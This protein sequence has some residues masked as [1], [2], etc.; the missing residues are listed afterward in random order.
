MCRRSCVGVRGC[1]LVEVLVAL[2]LITI[3]LTGLAQLLAVTM[4]QMQAARHRSAA[5][6]LAAAKLEQLQ[7]LT[8]NVRFV[9]GVPVMGQDE[10]T[11]LRIEP[12]GSSG[13]GTREVVEVVDYL[14]AR[15]E[16]V[17]GGGHVPVA[18]AYERRW[19]VVRRGEGASGLLVFEVAVA[20]LSRLR[21]G[22]GASEVDWRVSPHVVWLYGARLRRASG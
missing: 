4:S 7:A 17:G 5:M 3:A 11:D 10:V 21:A 18:A 8:W 19:S 13:T 6:W 9:E 12:G 22:G 1:T 20:D 14:D 15:G 16:W 2:V